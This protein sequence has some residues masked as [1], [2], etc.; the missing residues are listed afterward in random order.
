[1]KQPAQTPAAGTEGS[2]QLDG[3]SSNMSGT[4][5]RMR[6]ICMGSMLSMTTPRYLQ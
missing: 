5:A 4:C 3:T 6:P 1:M 2:A